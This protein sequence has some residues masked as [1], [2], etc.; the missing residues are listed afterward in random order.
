MLKTGNFDA[1]A[2]LNARMGLP[3]NIISEDQGIIS[4]LKFV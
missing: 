2:E 4:D 3:F 1:M